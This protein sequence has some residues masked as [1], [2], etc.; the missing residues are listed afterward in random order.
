[1]RQGLQRHR[2]LR[3]TQQRALRPQAV[4]L[5][6]VRRKI[7]QLPLFS[8]ASGAHTHSNRPQMPAVQE[9]LQKQREPA[10]TRAMRARGTRGAVR[11]KTSVR[12]VRQVVCSKGQ[13][14]DALQNPHRVQTVQML[15]LRQ[16][17]HEEGVFG[18]ARENSQRGEAVRL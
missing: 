2:S 4:Y 18:V 10:K 13:A 17:V 16:A 14:R 3:R 6:R 9:A 11:E 12:H 8:V 5:R 1:M 15:A 7:P